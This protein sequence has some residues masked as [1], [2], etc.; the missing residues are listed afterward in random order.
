MKEII[1][2]E[3]NFLCDLDVSAG[4]MTNGL[5]DHTKRS[6]RTSGKRYRGVT[7]KSWRKPRSMVY[8]MVAARLVG[9]LATKAELGATGQYGCLLMI[10]SNFL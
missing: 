3:R 10:N 5:C 7:S 4:L 1:H 8:G 2:Q 6:L 9:K